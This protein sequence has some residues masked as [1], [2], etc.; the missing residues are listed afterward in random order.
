MPR[1]RAYKQAE[2][3]IPVDSA[4]IVTAFQCPWTKQVWA[5]KKAYIKHLK[6]LREE[7]IHR[8][9]RAARL[10][11][12]LADLNNQPTWMDVIEWIERNSH[13][14]LARAKQNNAWHSD[15][16]KWPAP[17]DFWIRITFLDIHHTDCASNTHSAPR[18]KPTNWA[19]KDPNLP[20]GYPG[21]TGRIEWQTSHYLQDLAVTSCVALEF[22]QAVEAEAVAT[23]M[24]TE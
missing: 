5:T 24:V 2:K 12:M 13:F 8:R 18:G 21:W 20:N 17:E 7:R 6:Q 16:R 3:I 14:F 22:V 10:D 11:K 19:H 1:I 9:I 15:Y 4:K 23:D